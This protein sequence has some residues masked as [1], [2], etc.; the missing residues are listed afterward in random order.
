MKLSEMEKKWQDLWE[1]KAVFQTRKDKKRK[2][3]YVLEMFPYPSGSGLHMGHVRNYAL[4]DAFARFKRMQGFNVLYPMGY[5]AFGLPAENAAI[6][7]KTHP[8]DYTESA[9]RTIKKQQKALG[10]SYDWSR[11][12]ITCKPEYYRWNQWLFLK[13]MKKGLVYKK[14]SPINFCPSCKTV[15]ANE[16]VESGKCWRC[17]S[18]VTIK[19]LAQWFLKITEYANDLLN[20]LKKLDWPENVKTMQENWIGKSS[21]TMVKFKIKGSKK[22]IQIF[23]T[24]PDTLY[25]VTFLVYAPEHPDVLSLTSPSR[26]KEV[27]KFI[28]KVM[29]QEKFSRTEKGKEGIYIGKKAIHPLTKEEIPIHIANF[30]LM[31][32]GTGAIMAVPAHDQRDFEFAKKYKIPIK[33]VITPFK[34]QAPKDKAFVDEGRLVSSGKFTG[35]KS[36]VAIKKITDH[37]EKKKLGE[38]KIQFHL[39]D[40]LISRQRY[41]GTPIP[42][43]YCK[44]CGIQTVPEKDLPVL[45]PN[46]IK[47]TGK[48]NPLEKNKSFLEAKCPECSGPA[49]RETDTMDTFVDSAWYYFRYCTPDFKLGPF[50]GEADYWMPVDQYIGGVEHA[51]LHLLYARF[52]TKAM[53]DLELTKTKEPFS[54]LFT[55]GMVIKD[56]A[57]MSKS[58]GNIVS[59]EEISKKYGID[60]AR[61]FLLFVAAPEK[62]LEWSDEGISGAHRFLKKAFSLAK[63]AKGRS[64][65]ETRDKLMQSKTQRLIQR[66]TEDISNFRFN[67]AVVKLM[68]F[69]NDIVKYKEDP[70]KDVLKQALETLTTLLSPFCPHIAEEM[71]ESLENKPFVSVQQWPKPNE[72]LINPALEQQSLL[73]E[74][75]RE[76]IQEILKLVGKKPEKIQVFAAPGWKYTV[77]KAIKSSSRGFSVKELMK[78]P[79]VRKHGKDAVR[80]AEK[81]SKSFS[82]QKILSEA[83]E[84]KALKEAIPA[85]EKKF[86]CDVIVKPAIKS[87][88]QKARK[89]EPGKPGIEVSF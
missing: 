66:V 5:D 21:G 6:K 67:L 61:L 8:K 80:F 63:P 70:N 12:V 77:H 18:V 7:S 27:K 84:L 50:G 82:V 13:F 89:A 64:K 49:T 76:D 26:K 68:G 3:F 73:V 52:F 81:L 19:P 38:K 45:L 71:W 86:S 42:I 1:E 85:L 41:W 58:V 83:E 51:I 31:E 32:Y 57:K 54:G 60:T 75:T 23:T 43:I 87:S 46:D 14:E 72:K 69:A 62:E 20:D 47:F 9:I 4:G 10:L 33:Q 34:G 37:L 53:S 88:S 56:G 15:L 25:G 30:V 39:R 36:D 17:K 29:L 44:K 24:R 79:E 22:E 2:K 48:G 65:L 55:Q 16:Q 11:E 78:I 40:W 28:N 59:Q 74:Q 35:V